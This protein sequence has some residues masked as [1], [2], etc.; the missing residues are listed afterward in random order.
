MQVMHMNWKTGKM[1]PCVEHRL[2]R[3]QIV[4]G[5]DGPSHEY[6]GVVL[7]RVEN[8]KWGTSCRILWIDDLRVSGHQFIKPITERFGIGVYF[9]PGKLM[10]EEKIAELE[11]RYLENERAEAIEAEKRRIENERLAVI[12]KEHFADAIKKHGKP[13]AL[14]LAVEHEDVSDLQTDYF[15][16]RTVRTV[17]LA[18]SKHKRN[19]FPEM[20]KA[21]LN[22][23]IPEIRKLATAPADWENREDYSGGHGYYLA[24]SKY[25]GWSIEKIPLYRENQLEEFYCN[26]G[27]PRGFCVK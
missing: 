25:S 19:L 3:G 7:E 17:V 24:E 15:D 21:A 14:I 13:V 20:R 27:K 5:I 16:Y 23:D 1:E 11:K 4:M 6:D 26:A 22:S 18:F 8:G 12:G 10:P 2:E 9:Y